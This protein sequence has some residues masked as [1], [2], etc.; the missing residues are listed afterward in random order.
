MAGNIKKARV[1]WGHL[2]RVLGREGADPTV[3][4]NFYTSVTQQVLLFGVD[5]WVL[6]RKME[7]ALDAF[8]DRFARKLMGRHPRR[9]R[10]GRWFYPSLVG[11]RKEAGI[12]RILT[13]ILWRQNTVAQLIVT[14]PILGPTRDG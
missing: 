7:S 2:V 14:Q 8:Q 5:M 13:S 1:S 6:T 3:S 9:G 12:V 10:G 4:R 11:D